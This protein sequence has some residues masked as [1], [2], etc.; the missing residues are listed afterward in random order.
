MKLEK[1]TKISSVHFKYVG[2]DEQFSDQLDGT[3]KQIREAHIARGY[4]TGE[5]RYLIRFSS[6]DASAVFAEHCTRT[7]VRRVVQVRFDG[8]E[9]PDVSSTLAAVG[10]A[11]EW[12]TIQRWDVLGRYEGIKRAAYDAFLDMPRV[13]T[14]VLPRDIRVQYGKV[15]FAL[16]DV[17]ASSYHATQIADALHRFLLLRYAYGARPGLRNRCQRFWIP[18][19]Q[20]C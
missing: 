13:G 17:D 15:L 4:D 16:P 6:D 10:I 12:K 5:I 11:C 3:K 14:V 1:Q 18:L 9:T 8:N 2:T 20:G 19:R 7:G